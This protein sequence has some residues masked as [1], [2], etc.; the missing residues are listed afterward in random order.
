MQEDNQ[1]KN[2]QDKATHKDPTWIKSYPEHLKWED[3]INVK[4]IFD[5]MENT[6]EKYGDRP[7]FDFLGKKYKWAEMAE[8]AD[9]LARGLQTLGIGKN[10][11][12]G[13]FLPNC[14]MFVV[15]F[16]AITKIG[17][18]VVHYNPLYSIKELH[19]Q[20]E[21]SHT[22]LMITADLKMLHDKMLEMLSSTRLNQLIICPFTDMLP[23]PKSMLFKM[24]KGKE[25]ATIP[26]DDRHFPLE[27]VMNNTGKISPV[28]I[29]P[30]KDVALLQ[31]TGGTTGVP[32][33]AMLTHANI[34]ANATQCVE[35]CKQTPY[36]EGKMVGVL[37]F[38]HVFALTAVMNFS[39]YAGLEIVALPRFDLKQTLKLIHKH[40]P[41]I[42]P[43][44]PAIYNAINNY[45]DIDKYDLTSILFCISGG[46]PLPV[47]VKKDFEERTGCVVVE[48][49]GL[50]EAAP[51]I[52]VN[53][54]EGV[55]KP[56]SIGMPVQ[57]TD[58]RLWDKDNPGSEVKP[59]ERGELVAKG[60]QIM[61]GY[62][63]NE[64]ATKSTIV[65]GYLRTGDIATMDDEG[66]FFIVDRIKDMIIT[67]GYNVYPRNVEDAI[68]QH[69][70]VEECIV[71]GLPDEDRGEVIKAWIK[72]K[73]GRN[74]TEADL[75]DFL[76]E[77]LSPMEMPRQIEVRDEPLPK[78]MIGK[79]SR[80]DI[81]A[82][83]M[84]KLAAE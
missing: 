18:T 72:P 47:E 7:A 42:F 23:F 55:N 84:Q 25:L 39:V 82:E 75:R 69:P 46:A 10:S 67:N 58:V 28:D 2:T 74:L 14:P 13:I 73:E 59:G 81:V 35:W 34:V 50:T 20:I 65:D 36:G 37:P 83:E 19:H 61:K 45:P 22:D 4:P 24:L 11:K 49:Y 27:K 48:G 79:L 44:V 33:G 78:T 21:D 12:V 77:H 40:R 8:M 56:G 51:V 68:Y 5:L 52:C 16:Y 57:N 64:E 66:Y 29:D 1:N 70:S 17:A 41:Q 31:Y 9:R 71:A 30:Y 3:R 43:A 54:T 15:A 53:P 62:W 76:K 38:F 32:K 6:R 80:K 63:E 26:N 60:P